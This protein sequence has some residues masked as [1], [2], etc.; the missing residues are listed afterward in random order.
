M[1]YLALSIGGSNGCG[2]ASGVVD[3][4]DWVISGLIVSE[5]R[6][7]SVGGIVA[8][9]DVISD[10]LQPAEIKIN[11]SMIN[12]RVTFHDFSMVSGIS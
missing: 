5:E 9:A 6:L 3:I 4:G 2:V 1:E 8:I 7:G 11:T 12:Q 10:D